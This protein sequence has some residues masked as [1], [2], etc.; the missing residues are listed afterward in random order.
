M[1]AVM[2]AKQGEMSVV[3]DMNEWAEKV[4]APSMICSYEF[5]PILNELYEEWG[6]SQLR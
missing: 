2:V 1:S 4:S 6:C 5:L 3:G